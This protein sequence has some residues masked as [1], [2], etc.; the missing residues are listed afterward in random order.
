MGLFGLAA[1]TTERRIKEIGI[2]KVLGA[3]V[4]NIM[5]GLSKS[6]V[7]LIL[8]AF[9]IMTPLAWLFLSKWLE[10]FAYHIDINPVV[11]IV[12]MV[13]AV[14]IALATISY[15]TLK[16]AKANPVDALRYE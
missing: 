9:V 14:A 3:S 4:I 7:L 12:S 1:I 15:H 6:F 16:S 10:K 2:R 5:Y 13:I 11:F 8:I